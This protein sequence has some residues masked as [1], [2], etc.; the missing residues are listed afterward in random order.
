MAAV[1]DQQAW[2]FAVDEAHRISEWGH[3]FLPASLGLRRAI[4]QIVRPTI[5]APTATATPNERFA[6]PLRRS[7]L[8]VEQLGE[9]SGLSRARGSPGRNPDAAGHPSRARWRTAL[10]RPRL[11]LGAHS[12]AG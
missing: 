10:A 9:D 1:R 3:D 5:L 6:V 8:A 12:T 4:E 2:L 11:R 7:G